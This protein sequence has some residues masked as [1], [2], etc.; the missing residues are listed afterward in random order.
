MNKREDSMLDADVV[1]IGDNPSSTRKSL[2]ESFLGRCDRTQKGRSAEVS[3]DRGR[4]SSS[5]DWK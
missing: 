1:L 3:S 2:H 5:A 4:T